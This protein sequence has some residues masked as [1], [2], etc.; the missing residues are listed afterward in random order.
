MR[1]PA[2]YRLKSRSI[3]YIVKP[4]LRQ[5]NNSHAHGGQHDHPPAISRL[6]KRMTVGGNLALGGIELIAGNVTA[7]AVAADGVH[8][9]GDAVTY[10]MQADDILDTGM[11]QERLQ[12]RRQIAHWLIAGSSAVIGAKAG[13]DL[14]GDV[15]LEASDFAMYAA[16]ASLVYNGGLLYRLRQGIARQHAAAGPETDCHREQDLVKHFMHLDIPSAALAVGGVVAQKYGV[17]DAG[18]LAGIASGVLGVVAFRPTAGNLNHN[19]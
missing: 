13:V 3:W 11:T 2:V 5:E 16:G 18:Q 6:W 9:I 8:N 7:L 15:A 4:M 1:K 12:K 14:M 19:H 10:S 17:E